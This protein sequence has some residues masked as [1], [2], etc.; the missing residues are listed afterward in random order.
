MIVQKAALDLVVLPKVHDKYLGTLQSVLVTL[1]CGLST[2]SSTKEG[3]NLKAGQ[4]DLQN[5]KF[6]CAS[7]ELSEEC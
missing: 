6:S 3:V 1:H 4:F 7:E 5:I 2:W